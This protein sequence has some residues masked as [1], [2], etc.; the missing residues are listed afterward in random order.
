MARMPDMEQEANATRR[1]VGRT[2]IPAGAART[3]VLRRTYDAGIEDLWDALTNPERLPR[4]FLPVT[5]D[6]QLGG[7][8]QLQ[9]NAGGEIRTCEPP[10]LLRVTWAYGE[11]ITDQD[12]GEVE[13]RLTPGANGTTDFEL[14]HAA[15]PPPEFWKQFGPGAVG[16]GW[17]LALYGL[18][19]HLRGGSLTDHGV[20]PDTWSTSPDGVEFVRHASASWGAAHRAANIAAGDDP[21]EADAAAQGSFAF[22]TN[23][24][25]PST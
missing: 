13:V 17:D 10:K 8:Y 6:L 14:S 1:E 22:Y 4:W 7:K 2:T 25:P 16:I 23:T 9:G 11:N 18:V 12:I 15:V 21:A 3:V 20:D 19:L 24:L 5:G